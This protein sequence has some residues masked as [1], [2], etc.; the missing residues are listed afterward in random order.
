MRFT[1][2]RTVNKLAPVH[3]SKKRKKKGGPSKALS[4]FDLHYGCHF[5]RIILTKL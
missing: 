4:Y 5:D 1:L 2:M 3:E